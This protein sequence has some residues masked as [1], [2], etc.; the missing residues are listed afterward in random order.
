MGVKIAKAD[1]FGVSEQP[2]N[3]TASADQVRSQVLQSARNF[4]ESWKDLA[5][6]LHIVWEE[7]FYKEWGY[8]TFDHYTAKEIHIRKHTAMKLIHSYSF[9]QKEEIQCLEHR[10]GTTKA[11]TPALSFDTVNLLRSAKKNLDNDTYENIKKDVLAEK[12][13]LKDIKKDLTLLIRQRKNIDPEAERQKQNNMIIKR[14]VSTLKS[15]KRDIQVL[16]LLPAS[17]TKDIDKLIHNI[18]DQMPL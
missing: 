9:L 2:L 16:K 3:E 11:I 14:F 12:T 17:I 18:E 1:S 10:D 15:L 6:S 8:D 13:N 5:R 7:K 4:K